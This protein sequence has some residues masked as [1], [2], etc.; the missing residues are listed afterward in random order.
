MEGIEEKA[1]RAENKDI[2]LEAK[3]DV[4]TRYDESRKV[5]M[6]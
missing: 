6:L 2:I 4:L 1:F 3:W 5:C